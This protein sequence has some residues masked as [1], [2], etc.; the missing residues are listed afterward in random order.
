MRSWNAEMAKNL[1]R[2]VDKL[3]G[4]TGGKDQWIVISLPP[5]YDEG[6]ALS[7]LGVNGED[8]MFFISHLNLGGDE[9]GR[10]KLLPPW[11]RTR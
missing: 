2:R 5:G 10:P 9:G 7:E 8:V 1:N 3:E 11:S 4:A 6:K